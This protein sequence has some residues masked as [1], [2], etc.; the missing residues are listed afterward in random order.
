MRNFQEQPERSG[1]RSDIKNYMLRRFVMRSCYIRIAARQSGFTLIEMMIA[2]LISIFLILGLLTILMS[3]RMTY[4]A[5]GQLA[6]QHESQ[7]TFLAVLGANVES[8]GYFPIGDP[9]SRIN[10]IDN[11]LPELSIANQKFELGQG[12]IGNADSS[13]TTDTLST[14]FQ[15]APGDGL[16]NCQGNSNTTAGNVT[17]INTFTVINTELVCT[18]STNGAAPN[19]PVVLVQNVASLSL[20]YGVDTDGND[21]VDTYLTAAEV[22]ARG[23]WR[24][25][26]SVELTLAMLDPFTRQPSTA[27]PKIVQNFS[28]ANF[29]HSDLPVQKP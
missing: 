20:L 19:T 22:A 12:I 4:T 21:S 16:V 17:Y 18:V 29:R 25:V 28:A 14:R 13:S 11:A 24:Y 10:T 2:L 3:V 1:S 7:R 5:E 15:T 26:R 8:A 27:L 23:L 6:E 9:V